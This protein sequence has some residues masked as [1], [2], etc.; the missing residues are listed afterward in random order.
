LAKVAFFIAAQNS[1]HQ[2]KHRRPPGHKGSAK[3]K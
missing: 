3:G 2:F 1:L